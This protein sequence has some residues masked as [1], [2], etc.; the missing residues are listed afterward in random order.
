VHSDLYRAFAKLI[1]QSDPATIERACR[2]AVHFKA[3]D[4]NQLRQIVERKLYELP[5]EEP[6]TTPRSALLSPQIDV[7]RPLEL[8]SLLFGGL[9]VDR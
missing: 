6:V 3:F 8:Y 4:L 5:H 2:R 1:E 7:A 9:H